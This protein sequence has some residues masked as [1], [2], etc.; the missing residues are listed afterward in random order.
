MMALQA[1]VKGAERSCLHVSIW[2]MSYLPCL[3]ELLLLLPKHGM[4]HPTCM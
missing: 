2:A 3:S 4:S 1:E